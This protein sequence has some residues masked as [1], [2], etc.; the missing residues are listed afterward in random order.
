MKDNEIEIVLATKA[1]GLGINIPIIRHVV[2]VG[3]SE[4]LSLWMQEFG[5]AGRDGLQAY[6]QL[7]ICERED[8]KKVQY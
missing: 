3:L 7:L 1:F 2:H 4:S 6:A 5:R 8:F